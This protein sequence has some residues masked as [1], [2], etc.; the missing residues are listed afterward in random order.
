M[1]ASSLLEMRDVSCRR[2]DAWIAGATLSLAPG[3]LCFLRG[4]EGSTLLLR[5]ATLLELPD[6]GCLNLG[7]EAVLQLDEASQATVRSRLFGF[8]FD[9]P[10]LLPEMSVAENIA[11]PLFKVLDLDAVAARD[12]TE[13]T[14]RFAGLTSLATAQCGE[15]SWFDQQ[16]VAVARAVAHQPA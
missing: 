8:V 11:M 4:D 2:G 13:A 6:S 1:S 12:R 10:Y 14:L 9:A 3:A 16:R 5:V 7:G 15:L